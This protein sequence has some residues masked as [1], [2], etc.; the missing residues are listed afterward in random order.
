MKTTALFVD[1][2]IIGLLAFLWIAGLSFCFFISTDWI[3]EILSKYE[4]IG[5]LLI[6]SLIYVLG[7]MF[8]YTN[9]WIFTF[10]KSSDDKEIL[11]D[12]SVIKIL[13]DNPEVQKF[14]DNH[15]SRLR[16]ARATII[17]IPLIF[18]TASCLLF[19]NPE[20]SSLPNCTS[21]ITLWLIMVI[22]FVLSIHSYRLRNKTYRNY[23][24]ETLKLKNTEPNKT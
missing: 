6:F 24:K 2:L 9:A 21:Q 19:K 11:K 14:L 4:I 7:I 15:Y 1:I 17:S 22:A 23:L 3:L 18:G 10:F 16:I 8:D 5:T 20:I 13:H 12:V